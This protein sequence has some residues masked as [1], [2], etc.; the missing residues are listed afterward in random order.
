MHGL[1]LGVFLGLYAGNPRFKGQIDRALKDALGKGV[2]ILNK[3]TTPVG[4]AINGPYDEP[5]AE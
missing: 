5:P 4:G 2:D 3:G 1:A